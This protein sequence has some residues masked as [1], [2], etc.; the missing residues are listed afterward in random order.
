MEKKKRKVRVEEARTVSRTDK[1][2]NNV[3]FVLAVGGE[4]Y[5]RDATLAQKNIN[6]ITQALA[7]RIMEHACKMEYLWTVGHLGW[8]VKTRSKIK[9]RN[10]NHLVTSVYTQGVHICVQKTNSIFFR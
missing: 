10:V 6:S 3:E 7:S 4:G 2:V 9:E 5:W 1:S 8:K